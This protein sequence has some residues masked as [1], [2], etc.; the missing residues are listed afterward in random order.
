MLNSYQ[1]N[2]QPL[3]AD[4]NQELLDFGKHCDF[5]AGSDPAD[6]ANQTDMDSGRVFHETTQT[7]PAYIRKFHLPDSIKVK[8][9][10]HMNDLFF[11]NLNFYLQIVF[12]GQHLCPHRDANRRLNIAYN[13]SG[14]GATTHFHDRLIADESRFIFAPSEISEPVESYNYKQH[15]WYVFN[16]QKI[17]SVS[18]LGLRV[19]RIALAANIK[20]EYA[21]FLEKYKNNL[22]L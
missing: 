19:K 18:N 15:T 4:L 22:V 7:L 12:A 20:L 17:H 1:L 6:K 2:F 14:D 8:I 3:S 16:N 5:K 13:L 10:D 9:M 11:D 21:D